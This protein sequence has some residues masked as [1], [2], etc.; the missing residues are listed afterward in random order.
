MTR[1]PHRPHA[2]T[3]I[4]EA[5]RFRVDGARRELTSAI[6]NVGS[7]ETLKGIANTIA[8]ARRNLDDAQQEL[9]ELE[10]IYPPSCWVRFR[11]YLAP[12]RGGL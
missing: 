10:A 3:A 4:I 11:R 1:E 5:A 8:L 2:M 12:S 6:A 9:A 7:E